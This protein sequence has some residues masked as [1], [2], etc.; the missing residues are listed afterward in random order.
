MSGE[1]DDTDH[2]QFTGDTAANPRG[3]SEADAD[4]K[5]L[6]GTAVLQKAFDIL[7]IIGSVPGEIDGVELSRRTGIPRATLYRILSALNKRGLVRS[8]PG[9]QTYSLGFHLIELA[10]NVW[11]SNDLV[12]VS[13]AE[14][15]H[16]RDMTGETSYLAV[17][18]EGAVRALG[19]FDGAHSRRSSAEL[20]ITK[21][22]HCTSQGKAMM[23]HLS[24]AQVQALLKTPLHSYTPKTITDIGQLMVQLEIS[25][26]RGFAID[27]EEILEET[28]CVG[29]AILDPSGQPIAAISVAG[30]S[31]RITQK[32]AEQL[33]HEIA[34]AAKR[35]EHEL[36]RATTTRSG[37]SSSARAVHAPQ[38][39]FGAS[40]LWDERT[41]SLVWIDT[42]AP[43][44]HWTGK[45]TA[46]VS[47]DGLEKQIDG[48]FLCDSGLAILTRGGIIL[49]SPAGQ[50]DKLDFGAD[51]R[52]AAV[53]VDSTGR[54][55]L[56]QFD[57]KSNVSSIGLLTPDGPT[58]PLFQVDGEVSDLAIDSSGTIFATVPSRSLIYAL[59]EKE[60]RKR[61]FSRLPEATG[62]PMGL[63]ID[64][65][66]RLWVVVH[67]GWS[68]IRL[69]DD[70]EFETVLPLP[71]PSPT[72][73]AFGGPTFSTLYV[74]SARTGLTSE[75][76]QNAP[77]SGRLLALDAPVRGLPETVANFSFERARSQQA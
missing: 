38:A 60:G 73:L 65:E 48:A 30:P 46:A 71:V 62:Q 50:I 14:L 21:P 16:L 57:E 69:D 76:L 58:A 55:W 24:R 1:I 22:L 15:R 52:A 39:F 10:Q 64:C 70:G 6:A 47:L 41:Q 51:F 49:A 2:V 9:K 42:L 5:A 53:R 8:E 66:N 26:A 37:V 54:V 68:V 11:S 32:R 25:K 27:D 67:E 23:S 45:T 56:A 33:G 29:A 36:N 77:Q 44:A 72:S 43:A 12:S 75:L 34:A 13:S 19:R 7:D 20:G 4:H 31:F 18:H 74:T 17:L 59:S 40:A 28:R 3:W 35:I 61:V 63:A